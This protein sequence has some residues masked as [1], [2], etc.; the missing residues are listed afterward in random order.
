MALVLNQQVE[1]T[2][3]IEAEGITPDQ[4]LGKSTS[5]IE[6]LPLWH[7]RH[8]LELAQLFRVSGS[9][10]GP[11]TIV[12]EGNLNSVNGIGAGM[13]SGTIR[14]ESNTGS[15]V[16]SQM[17]GGEIIA[18][19]VSDFLGVEMTGGIIHVTGNA[20]DCVGGQLPGSKF[21]MNRGSILVR[22]NVGKGAGQGMRRGTIVIGGDAGELLG[23][24]MLAGTIVVFGHC[25]PYVGA[26]MTRGS[27]IL[28]GGYP[29]PLLPTFAIGGRFPVPVL[30]MLAKWLR[31]HK[32]PL[33]DQSLTKPF[34][35]FHGD[36]LK[37]GRGELF[38]DVG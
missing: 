16:G 20:G 5:L 29:R 14:I 4:L 12:F 23:W 3:P 26:E 6:K 25:G 34:Q 38:V 11:P 7:G 33:D 19:D 32:F 37:G 24:N 9:W 21:G 35:I 30:S 8:R 36:G 27:I 18:R 28:A 22:G 13:K 15:R 10:D 31:D 2:I 17:S 1:T